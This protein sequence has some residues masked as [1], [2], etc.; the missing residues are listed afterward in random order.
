MSSEEINPVALSTV[1][2]CLSEGIRKFQLN[3][4]CLKFHNN[5]SEDIFGLPNC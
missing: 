5:L 4:K 1:E 2:L 3:R